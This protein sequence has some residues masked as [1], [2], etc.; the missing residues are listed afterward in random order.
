M[1]EGVREAGTRQDTFVLYVTLEPGRG[2]LSFDSGVWDKRSGGALDSDE[3]KY[4]PGRMQDQ[5]SLGGRRTTDNVVLS[6]LYDIHDDHDIID[7][8]LNAVGRGRVTVVQRPMD[9]DGNVYRGKALFWAGKL[10]RVFVPEV[11]SES[12]TAA[13]VEIEVSVAGIPHLLV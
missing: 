9:Q 2:L 4:Y 5:I 6:R 11:D 13:M 12:T 8:W 3:V 7:I 1:A 10:K